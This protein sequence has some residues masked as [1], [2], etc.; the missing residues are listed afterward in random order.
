[1]A[2][3]FHIPSALLEEHVS[4]LGLVH[5]VRNIWGSRDPEVDP[6]AA[7]VKLA[8]WLLADHRPRIRTVEAAGV[9]IADVLGDRIALP[10]AIGKVLYDITGGE[11]GLRDWTRPYSA[12]DAAHHAAPVA[13]GD[14]GDG[15]AP[16]APSSPIRGRLG[17]VP[18]GPLFSVAR[19]DGRFILTGLGIASGAMDESAATAACRALATALGYEL[20]RAGE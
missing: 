20:R 9:P 19:E 12:P 4:G 5:W 18:P 8:A 14:D 3:G 1:M 15:T 11:I 2:G 6:S 16:P 10:P 13:D 17:E 7:V